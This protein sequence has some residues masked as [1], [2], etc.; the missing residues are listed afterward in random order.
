MK[1]SVP[2]EYGACS[3]A[4]VSGDTVTQPVR[5]T[6]VGGSTAATLA[7][8]L[9]EPFCILQIE[10]VTLCFTVDPNALHSPAA[11]CCARP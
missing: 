9:H 10:H 3:G 7:Q 5:A 6:G 2:F 4:V 8:I 1:A 11:D